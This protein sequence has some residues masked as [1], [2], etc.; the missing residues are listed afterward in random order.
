MSEEEQDERRKQ[1]KEIMKDSK[2]SQLEK[3]RSI[4]SLMDGRRRNSTGTRS[5]CSNEEADHVNNISRVAAVY[6]SSD[7]EGDAYMSDAPDDIYDYD[8]DDQ[9]SVASS[10]THTSHHGDFILPGAYRK[11]HG[12][13][14]S[15]QEFTEE[16][17]AAAVANMSIFTDN[18]EQVSRLMEKSRPPCEHYERNCTIISPCCGLAFGCR[19]CHDECPALPPPLA[20]RRDSELFGE[21]MDSMK[22]SS[23]QKLDRRFSMPLDFEDDDENH[24]LIDRF[25][26]REVICRECFTRQSSK[27]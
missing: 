4:Q 1:I 10:V 22:K 5:V 11:I 21:K 6:Y 12:R 2:L 27:T 24:H 17:R 20:M 23:Q 13:A 14:Y 7:E 26:I 3:S 19:I 15:L 25:S 8:K 18:P 16:S 9:R